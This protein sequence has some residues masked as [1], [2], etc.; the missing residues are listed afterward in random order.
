MFYDFT[1][2]HSRQLFYTLLFYSYTR[3]VLD[4]WSVSHWATVLLKVTTGRN[5]FLMTNFLKAL[6]QVPESL[7][8]THF[9][10]PLAGFS[11]HVGDETRKENTQ[12][13][14]CL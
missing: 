14:S 4:I 7:P 1:N 8:R 11:L 3:L 5:R 13:V 6:A 12:L 9:K 10:I 2:T